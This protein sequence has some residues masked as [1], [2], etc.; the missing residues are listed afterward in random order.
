MIEDVHW[1]DSS[2]VD[3]LEYLLAPAHAVAVPVVLTCRSEESVSPIVKGWLDRLQRN[4][5]VHRLDLAPLSEAETGEQIAFLLGARPPRQLVA[6]T[7]VRSEGNAFFTEQLI[8]AH[9]SRDDDVL[10]AGMTSLLLSRA[11]R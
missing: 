10:P 5:R 4:P 6:D 3:L 8:A 9:T 11:G 2:T 1:V 7:Y